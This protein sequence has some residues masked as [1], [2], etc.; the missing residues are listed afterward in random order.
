MPS[1]LD[2]FLDTPAPRP[3]EYESTQD[4]LEAVREDGR[5]AASFTAKDYERERRRHAQLM[6]MGAGYAD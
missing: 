3:E 1:E 2:K 5:R 6:D 4:Y